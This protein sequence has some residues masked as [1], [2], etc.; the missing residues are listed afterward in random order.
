MASLYALSVNGTMLYIIGNLSEQ[1]C[2]DIDIIAE[3]FQAT[4][5]NPIDYDEICQTFISMVRET[6]NISLT[7]IPLKNIF[8]I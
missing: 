4:V 2:I 3:S 8:R 5:Q 1:N 6:L 7:Q